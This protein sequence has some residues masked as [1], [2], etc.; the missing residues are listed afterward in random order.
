MSAPSSSLSR[1]RS[2]WLHTLLRPS[3]QERGGREPRKSRGIG[4]K[5]GARKKYLASYRMSPQFA[6]GSQVFGRYMSTYT[7]QHKLYA[8]RKYQCHLP[9]L[10]TCTTQTIVGLQRLDNPCPHT[11]MGS[12]IHSSAAK[13]K[14][15][16]CGQKQSTRP[17]PMLNADSVSPQNQ[18]HNN[19][20]K[21]R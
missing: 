1:R 8:P 10:T 18:H 2:C 19:N 13:P 14:V 5:E 16:A 3:P 9:M 12:S 4:K 15:K 7:L 6:V 21:N 11:H 17:L 20:I